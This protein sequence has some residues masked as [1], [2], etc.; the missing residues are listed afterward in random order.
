MFLTV[1]VL[2]CRR[3]WVLLHF[4]GKDWFWFCWINSGWQLCAPG[5][6][7]AEVWWFCVAVDAPLVSSDIGYH[8]V[9]QTGLPAMVVRS[10]LLSSG[11]TG[12]PCMSHLALAS[13]PAS[14]VLIDIYLVWHKSHVFKTYVLISF[15]MYKYFWN[16][17][18]RQNEKRAISLGVSSPLLSSCLQIMWLACIPSLKTS[19]PIHLVILRFFYVI[20]N[21]YTLVY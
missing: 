17:F 16:H 3:V 21:V 15:E 20:A 5:W 9:L 13:D 6:A 14:L 7:V 4:T 12:V 1:L 10:Q 2:V 19:F 18:P 11:V 8:Y